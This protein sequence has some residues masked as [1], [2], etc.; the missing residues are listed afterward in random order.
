[1]RKTREEAEKTRNE[2]LNTATDMFI[3]RG[4]TNT[5]LT[6]IARAIGVT[7][8]AIYWHFRNKEDILKQIAKRACDITV[9][10]AINSL[11]DPLSDETLYSFYNKMLTRPLDEE[12]YA[13][14]YALVSRNHDWPEEL[15]RDIFEMMNEA[16]EMERKIV[17][18][19]I[20]RTQEAGVIRQDVEAEK[21]AT[22]ITSVFSGLRM[23]QTK[24]MLPEGF[25]KYDKLLFD[26]FKQ[27]L[28]S[29]VL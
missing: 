15:R 16:L 3:E 29:M 7:K 10:R 8:G 27:T 26:S 24:N 11:V 21:V 6:E 13:K 2:I 22:V 4:F 14:L 5:S 12:H 20:T 25:L 9:Q 17:G 28:R 1:M 23:L 18:S 19:Y